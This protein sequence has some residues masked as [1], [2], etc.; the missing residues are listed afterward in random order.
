M[1]SGGSVRRIIS[2]KLVLL[3][4]IHIIPILQNENTAFV[5]VT[6]TTHHIV[7][8]ILILNTIIS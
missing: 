7:K 4:N 6:T 2:N 1:L 5:S 8:I 3:H